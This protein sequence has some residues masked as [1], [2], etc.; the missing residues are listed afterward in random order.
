[1]E[2][3]K[4]GVIGAGFHAQSHFGMIAAEPAMRLVGVAEIDSERLARAEVD[5]H[6][7]VACADYREMLDRTSPDVVYVV[8]LP[9][10][11]LPIVV[12]CIQR[13][14]HTSVEKSP[15]MNSAETEQMLD[16]AQSSSAK[17]M[18]SVD[19]RYF[20]RTLAIKQLV[21]DRGG[22][23]HA[24]ATY[25]KPPVPQYGTWP[26][27]AGVICDAIHHVDL[28]RW[29]A[30]D[31]L[32]QAAAVAEVYAERWRSGPGTDYHNAMVKFTNGR[33]GVLM[34]HYGIGFRIQR[35]E[36]HAEDF[37]AYL[38]LTKGGATPGLELFADGA[39]YE[40]AL[41]LDAVG[42]PDFNETRHLVDCIENDRQPWSHL[43]DAVQTMKLCEAIW[44]GHKGPLQ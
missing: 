20:P 23:V 3:L 8:T 12:D 16:A 10:H 43:E 25:N 42:G 29:L 44:A 18:V 24:A 2:Q 11:L 22:A 21:L 37:S 27:P 30:G 40:E 17:V 39:S 34:S 14:I 15:G 32:G 9:G 4:V 1:M 7:E 33:T 31:E 28:L 41:D 6:P 38:E 5:H 36:V 19:R 35:A 26:I 13:G